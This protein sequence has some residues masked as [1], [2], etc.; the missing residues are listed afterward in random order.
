[1]SCNFDAYGLQIMKTKAK[2]PR[3]ILQMLICWT[4]SGSGLSLWS[5]LKILEKILLLHLFLSHF[6]LL[7]NFLLIC[8]EATHWTTT[9]FSTDL[10]CLS[11]LKTVMDTIQSM[12]VFRPSIHLVDCVVFKSK[13][14]A[15]CE[16][17]SL[18]LCEFHY[19]IPKL[20]LSQYC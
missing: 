4:F 9:C 19:E 20:A 2:Y 7:L 14:S 18:S 1:M 15:V 16:L 3:W 11:L 5:S 13:P 10:L 17:I 6:S 8:L 12:T